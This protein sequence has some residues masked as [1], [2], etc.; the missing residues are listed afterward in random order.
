MSED[1][2]NR[3]RDV[4]RRL[5]GGSKALNILLA[6]DGTTESRANDPENVVKDQHIE[7]T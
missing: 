7:D 1:S 4:N 6:A 2:G 3:G 5:L